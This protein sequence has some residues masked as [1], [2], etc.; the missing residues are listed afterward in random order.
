MAFAC[1]YSIQSLGDVLGTF[2]AI[3]RGQRLHRLPRQG[4]LWDAILGCL[5]SSAL[6]GV[7][8]E[9][10][11][12]EPNHDSF[13]GAKVLVFLFRS[14]VVLILWLAVTLCYRRRYDEIMP[15]PGRSRF[16]QGRRLPYHRHRVA[17]VRWLHLFLL[18]QIVSGE[19]VE[20][21]NTVHRHGVDHTVTE[22][23]EGQVVF[24]PYGPL[25]Q[26]RQA[27]C[28]S[29]GPI[30]GHNTVLADGSWPLD[31]PGFCR[32]NSPYGDAS[33]VLRFVSTTDTSSAADFRR[34]HDIVSYMQ[35]PVLRDHL[36]E[37]VLNVY[38]AGHWQVS[39]WVHFWDQRNQWSFLHRPLQ[40]SLMQPIRE[41][42]T[43]AWRDYQVR[44]SVHVVTV[45]PVPR[46]P[47]FILV[48]VLPETYFVVLGRVS[49]PSRNW[50]GTFL[51]GP[52]RNW[53]V[54]DL[55]DLAVPA[56]LCVWQHDCTLTIGTV[57]HDW[58]ARLILYEGALLA[59]KEEVRDDSSC[60]STDD[61]SDFSGSSSGENQSWPDDQLEQDE[62]A[63]FQQGV[64]T[65]TPQA[66][67]QRRVLGGNTATPIHGIGATNLP[68]N[69][70]RND[71]DVTSIVQLPWQQIFEAEEASGADLLQLDQITQAVPDMVYVDLLQ[72]SHFQLQNGDLLRAYLGHRLAIGDRAFFSA[73][74]W[75]IHGVVAP[76]ADVCVMHRERSYTRSLLTVVAATTESQ[77]YWLT[78]AT[79]QP[80]PLTLRVFPV[81]LVLLTD[82]Q[83]Q[84]AMRVYL[85]D[86][87]Y[88]SSPKRVAVLYQPHET[89]RDI[90]FKLGLAEVCFSTTYTCVLES[91]GEVEPREWHYL[92]E[93]DCYHGMSFVLTLRSQRQANRQCGYEV[94]DQALMQ[95]TVPHG[96]PLTYRIR[97]YIRKH[98]GGDGFL[99]V[100]LHQ[101]DRPHEYCTR[102]RRYGQASR[103]DDSAWLRVFDLTRSQ[104]SEDAFIE[105]EPPPMY[106]QR[107]RLHLILYP[108]RA[109]ELLPVLIEATHRETVMLGS[110]LLW[111]TGNRVQVETLFN[112]ALPGHA[113]RGLSECYAIVRGRNYLIGHDMTL[114]DGDFIRISEWPG[115]S[116]HEDEDSTCYDSYN[117]SSSDA[118]A[119]WTSEYD[120]ALSVRMHEEGTDSGDETLLGPQDGGENT[121]TP[122]TDAD[123]YSLM[124]TETIQ[125]SGSP[126]RANS[127]HA[128]LNHRVRLA[129]D[130]V[131][132]TI[133]RSQDATLMEIPAA[134]TVSFWM[135]PGEG[136][137]VQLRDTKLLLRT[138]I[139]SWQEWVLQLWDSKPSEVQY[140]VITK[141]LPS[142]GATRSKLHV[143]CTSLQD[144]DHGLKTILLDLTFNNILQ[145]GAVRVAILAT[146]A[147]IVA[148]FVGGPI[149]A[150]H[151]V[152]MDF[153]M[154]W[155][156][157]MHYR[158]FKAMEIAA[159]PNA[160]YV[161]IVP[162]GK[163]LPPMCG[164]PQFRF[165]ENGDI[166]PEGFDEITLMQTDLHGI[167]PPVTLSTRSAEVTASAASSGPPPID[168]PLHST[169]QDETFIEARNHLLAYWQ[170]Q[171]LVTLPEHLLVHCITFCEHVTHAFEA[172]C[173]IRNLQGCPP[174]EDFQT[175]C[176]G[177]GQPT[178]YEHF[179][180]FPLP[181]EIQQNVPTILMVDECR[182][183]DIPV[184]VVYFGTDET[185]P[186]TY[187]ATQSVTA[188]HILDW[189][190]MHIDIQR[191]V[192]IEHN[193]QWVGPQWLLPLQPG[194]LISI[195]V[196]PF[197][198]DHGYEATDMGTGTLVSSSQVTWDSQSS[199]VDSLQLHFPPDQDYDDTGLFQLAHS[200]S[201]SALVISDS[202]E[203][204]LVENF[205]WQE[206]L[207][208][209]NARTALH[210]YWA[211]AEEAWAYYRSRR[212]WPTIKFQLIE[213]SGPDSFLQLDE[214]F[215]WTERSF[216]GYAREHLR[217][218]NALE[219]RLLLAVV[220]P[221]PTPSE[222]Y[223]QDDL[224][225][226][227]KEGFDLDHCLMYTVI[228]QQTMPMELQT[229]VDLLPCTLNRE[230][231][232][233]TFRLEEICDSWNHDCK[234]L[235]QGR[236]LPWFISWRAFQ[237][238]KV[239][240]E[241]HTDLRQEARVLHGM[242][243][244][245]FVQ[246]TMPDQ[247]CDADAAGPSVTDDAS[248]GVDTEDDDNVLLMQLCPLPPPQK[249]R[250]YIP[251]IEKQ[252]RP[253]NT[254]RWP[255]RLPHDGHFL[256]P[257]KDYVQIQVR[258]IWS[259][260]L[261]REPTIHFWIFRHYEHLVRMPTTCIMKDQSWTQIFW[262]IVYNQ[263]LQLPVYFVP[264]T[265]RH[266]G[267]GI[268][269][270]LV[271]EHDDFYGGSRYFLVE[272]KCAAFQV[273]AV[274]VCSEACQAEHLL[275][276]AEMDA[277]RFDNGCALYGHTPRDR[278]RILRGQL[279]TLPTG[280]Y[281]TFEQRSEER[282]CEYD[283]AIA[284]LI[285]GIAFVQIGVRW[286]TTPKHNQLGRSPDGVQ[287]PWIAGDYMDMAWQL[288]PFE[289]L[290][291][292]GNPV[293]WLSYKLQCLDDYFVVGIH[294]I[295]ID[296]TNSE[297]VN[298][299][300]ASWPY[301]MTTCQQQRLQV[302]KDRQRS[303]AC[304][305]SDSD[306]S[307][308]MPVRISLWDHLQPKP[309][310]EQAQSSQAT[311][312]ASVELPNLTPLLHDLLQKQTTVH[313]DWKQIRSLLGPTLH[314]A[315]D[316][317][318]VGRPDSFQ[319]VII[320]T[321]GSN[322]NDA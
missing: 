48:P 49:T 113:C 233:Q 22:H 178:N 139:P 40:V 112:I 43:R 41:Q 36:A 129:S 230:V 252:L 311:M 203:D 62:A 320:Y 187:V 153:E 64:N 134:V 249:I 245:G 257:N 256:P 182:G 251:V 219:Q 310:S 211:L 83:Y 200:C 96:T 253:W 289:Q 46:K 196:L 105:V 79:P 255:I 296:A 115:H 204:E 306:P 75:L 161:Q 312:Q 12:F 283:P 202:D 30:G 297:H 8:L 37:Y 109:A 194:D 29:E 121:A 181:Y 111:P 232:L 313:H 207:Q 295:V 133:T 241:V 235:H 120:Q 231:L 317:L 278:E 189:V 7:L 32:A 39:T 9:C 67:H 205:R 293:W 156:D 23:T 50:M 220:R 93:V 167:S 45:R 26:L 103:Q 1:V 104:G 234:I 59:F 16:A 99:Y 57:T 33:F 229:S 237:G 44:P 175:W 217:R 275:Q 54:S 72:I 288:D 319:E 277:S 154:Y 224:I 225:V 287:R 130:E 163:P 137:S 195:R 248:H 143:L 60:S 76:F 247:T 151:S 86:V 98:S 91:A 51:F 210:G 301:G 315:F 159:I 169:G 316:S 215:Q 80:P 227:V 299:V 124:Q 95:V 305:R 122:F 258:N 268:L 190:L 302:E 266:E 206:M 94:E 141:S 17:K 58:W 222:Q 185:R 18:L 274:S 186:F 28:H 131:Y 148:L 179:R 298:P 55:F 61:G 92:D 6:E 3:W 177:Q 144:R 65:A 132:A 209:A 168:R 73:Y 81:D 140:Y 242:W 19:V 174:Y 263:D 117:D 123:P 101:N 164:E 180:V 304:W 240:I 243:P 21:A 238:M 254:W 77:I 321:D 259:G 127:R 85:I 147:E 280:S 82:E 165:D 135:L 106:Q 53:R 128:F 284:N 125:T 262:N 239:N 265:K 119:S 14:Q 172:Q 118:S 31:A 110:A 322:T 15:L 116:D 25:H 193:H 267:D 192:V 107:A 223:E 290:R 13:D 307:T 152:L 270:V 126:P 150:H 146:V 158:V 157:G 88:P 24:S 38:N 199:V 260:G 138:E 272:Q 11:S 176:R 188:Q 155:H 89:V 208:R 97:D 285:E 114:F 264:V 5:F 276:N 318:R 303:H 198:W 70:S 71:V 4:V 162:K 261:P 102:F 69:D 149:E 291:P 160:A 35:R 20:V 166:L 216:I 34:D 74:V 273:T 201:G 246:Y 63:L 42:L 300:A 108:K 84:Q 271:L 56:N 286:S 142:A 279:L 250:R 212:Q 87:L 282:I 281:F 221:I 27:K 47:T 184:V 52:V 214:T 90:L 197:R 68:S 226:L 218:T 191:D 228:W 213:P 269:H 308:K 136:R 236:E 100:W 314:D 294:E 170:G 171:P 2:K 145:R 173:P 78:L 10:A 309:R 183:N 244:Y 66:R 292:P